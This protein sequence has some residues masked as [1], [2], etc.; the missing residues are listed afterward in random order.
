MSFDQY[1]QESSESSTASPKFD[2]KTRG[3]DK[4]TLAQK[5][6]LIKTV[7]WLYCLQNYISKLMH[8][9]YLDSFILFHDFFDHY[10]Y[11]PF[12]FMCHNLTLCMLKKIV[13]YSSIN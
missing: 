1:S 3:K 7:K 5:F 2:R 6:S 4:A 10:N 11:L 9:N 13:H 12:M 8:V